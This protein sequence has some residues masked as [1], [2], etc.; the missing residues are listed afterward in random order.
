MSRPKLNTVIE[1]P[2]ANNE[3]DMLN[4]QFAQTHS[5]ELETIVRDFG[6]SIPFS[7]VVYKDKIRTH[8]NRSAEEL[9]EAGKALL[10]S[11]EHIAKNYNGGKLMWGKFLTDLG[12]EER[13]AQRMIQ[14]AKKFYRPEARPLLQAAGSKAKLF[15]LLVLEED[16]ITKITQGTEDSPIA[17]DEIERMSSSELRK[18][19]REA[20]ADSEATKKVLADKNT[21]I[22]K[23]ETQL[24]KTKTAEKP[25]R[26]EPN[27][28]V[29]ALRT[30]L[31][32]KRYEFNIIVK[33]IG[34]ILENLRACDEDYVAT[35]QETF[36]ALQEAYNNMTAMAG[37][38]LL[39]D[40][41]WL[42]NPDDIEDA[43]FIGADDENT[44]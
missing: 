43:D 37:S 4:Q 6:N 15:E 32:E 16:E 27:Y 31:T 19:L 18:A 30:E 12:L 2:T 5:S 23:L 28:D 41:D 21:K 7:E 14:A 35:A 38:S 25:A 34:S 29:L 20:R 3:Q 36:A 40:K 1:M 39:E 22:D 9:L 10:V 44:H 8:L 42:P 33:H 11:R 13:L 17:I 26:P 24:E